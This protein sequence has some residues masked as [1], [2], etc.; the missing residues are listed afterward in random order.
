MYVA[1]NLPRAHRSVAAGIF[2]LLAGI[3]L[4]TTGGHT[5]AI[6]E[7][8]MLTVT[9]NLV[10]HRSVA[11]NAPVDDASAAYSSYGP[12]QSV[13][14]LPFYAAGRAIAAIFPP[15]GATW[16]VRAAISWYNPLVTAGV[17]ALLYLAAAQLGYGASV[18]IGLALLYGLAT[19][20]WPH[21]KTFF[22][23][24]LTALVLLG[25]FVCALI[26]VSRIEALRGSQP[27]VMGLPRAALVLL[28]VSG[29][30]G[31]LA[32][33]VKIQ[34]GLA[35]PVL[36]IYVLVALAMT[37]GHRR[38]LFLGLL[39]WGIGAVLFLL[40]LSLYLWSLF[41]SPVRTGYGAVG[42]IFRNDLDTG[43]YGL[44]I[45]PGKGI[46][47][48]A[49]VLVLWPWGIVRLWRRAWPVALLCL[50]MAV[51]HLLF[52]ARVNFWHGDGAWG[53]R[54]LNIILPFLVLPLAGF[55]DSL[56]QRRTPWRAALL[57]GL[58]LLTVPVQ[59][60]G[61]AINL[62]A[63]LNLQRDSER[64]Y[65]Y[66]PDSP[67]VRHLQ[68]AGRQARQFYDLY[69]APNSVALISGFSYSEG[70]R[71]Q[72]EQVPRWTLPRAE[73]A[74]RPSSATPRQVTL[75]LNGCREAGD[76]APVTLESEG[77]LL[78]A[79]T[80][81]PARTFHLLL[82]VG[83]TELSLQATAWDPLAAGVERAGP[84]GVVLQNVSARAGDQD[85]TLR[86]DLIPIPPVPTGQVLLRRWV[87]DYRYGHWD[88]W[89][90]Y[91]A[92]SGLPRMPSIL[93]AGGWVIAAVGLIAGGYRRL[94]PAGRAGGELIEAH[95]AA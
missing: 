64:R 13:A 50:L 1:P 21:S 10:L 42:R 16:A 79:G 2:A 84:L 24:P 3:F 40:V 88:F 71:D 47:W 93:L 68:L 78:A 95:P 82:P 91:L 77:M 37:L 26:A 14:A 65:F 32:P 28:F 6:D 39:A 12:L 80:T 48:Y 8:Q 62:N 69:F 23:E 66:P 85:L 4:L 76:A 61:L 67:I 29:M 43:L 35:L 49:P 36:G 11:I 31:G 58:L 7:E 38:P 34:S 44:L 83:R 5:Y 87:H 52:Y 55:L 46:F 90:W 15:H 51:V 54:Y 57:A 27:L 74:L 89:W 73:I 92:K 81:C 94:R 56:D 9:E 59:V 19:I 17:A 53:P 30:L 45:S 33:L 72:G 86:G 63:Y 22:A 20:A 25:S 60:A 70:D 75:A 41:G 18:S